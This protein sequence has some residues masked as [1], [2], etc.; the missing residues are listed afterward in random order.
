M[1]KV[2]DS[3]NILESELVPDSILILFSN[4]S[5]RQC[6]FDDDDDL[7]DFLTCWVEKQFLDT[8]FL[9]YVLYWKS[10]SSMCCSELLIR[11]L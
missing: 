3:W 1:I 5:K 4:I 9:I 2:W 10:F 6:Y 8:A 11:M 7:I